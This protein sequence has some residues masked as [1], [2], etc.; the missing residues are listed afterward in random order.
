MNRLLI[1]VSFCIFLSQQLLAQEVAFSPEVLENP[2]QNK[3]Q[4]EKIF[5]IVKT[6]KVNPKSQKNT[7]VL[8]NGYA[9]SKLSKT[10]NW[11]NSKDGVKPKEI[12]LVFSLYPKE[13]DY[14]LTNYHELLANRLKAL[15][16][17]D[18]ELNSRDIKWFLVLQTDCETED[19][20]KLLYHGI[21]IKYDKL[22]AKEI[23]EREKA[24]AVADASIAK[25]DFSSAKKRVERYVK[26]AGGM[27]DSS[28]F[29]I[30]D[31]HKQWKNVL[32]VV[33]WTSSMY[34]HSA[35]GL[36]WHL[37]N[38]DSSGIAFF[39]FFNDGDAKWET[40]KKLGTT[41][42]IYFSE[43]NDMNK[44]VRVFNTAMRKGLGGEI[45][46]NDVEAIVKSIEKFPEFSELILIADNSPM[47]DFDLWDQVKH[48]VRVLIA[49]GDWTVNPEYINLAYLT[50]GSFHTV[51]EDVYF[52]NES[53]IDTALRL[54]NIDFVLDP[55]LNLYVCR[56]KKQCRYAQQE[57][58]AR[59]KQNLAELKN[60]PIY[61]SMAKDNTRK[62]GLFAWLKSLFS[63]KS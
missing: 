8:Y 6:K 1:L 27:H 49:D 16:A 12:H 36:L 2:V 9:Q 23:K 45:P 37:N 15:F 44:V 35:Q 29:K 48:P 59:E 38:I 43:A 18:E 11:T 7:S 21:L 56:D 24:N 19:E 30:L 47:R 55:T 32:C 3:Q 31:R 51:N 52:G 57:I 20:A 50:G 63:K 28:V 46:E 34:Q 40:E 5:K 22:S 33:D 25:N 42:G 26:N 62:S 4:L 60:K 17:V 53:K 54:A 61:R 13:F 39:S 58:A 41:G 14:W 10:E